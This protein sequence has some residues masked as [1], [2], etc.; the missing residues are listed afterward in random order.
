MPASIC[1]SPEKEC[2]IAVAAEYFSSTFFL[3][4]RRRYSAVKLNLNEFPFFSL[5]RDNYV[6]TLTEYM[7]LEEVA[8]A[9]EIQALKCEMVFTKS[10]LNLLERRITYTYSLKVIMMSSFFSKDLHSNIRCLQ[11]PNDFPPVKKMDRLWIQRNDRASLRIQAN[12]T[13]ILLDFIIHITVDGELTF[14]VPHT[15]LLDDGQFLAE[16]YALYIMD[17]FDLIDL[18]F[19]ETSPE[20]T[21]A[22]GA[23]IQRLA[24]IFTRYSKYLLVNFYLQLKLF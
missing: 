7:R 17:R 10:T 13:D 18:M 6:Q 15:I 23:Q 21:D 14:N 20:I 19:P 4:A 16:R 24:T 9:L 2:C 3:Y 12:V 11:I 8:V 5:N 1:V 22:A